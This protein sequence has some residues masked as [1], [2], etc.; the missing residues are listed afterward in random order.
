MVGWPY[1]HVIHKA[2]PISAP[3]VICRKGQVAIKSSRIIQISYYTTHTIATDLSLILWFLF[4][5]PSN[6]KLAFFG[7]FHSHNRP[8]I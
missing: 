5:G 8:L 6:K 7:F 1:K 3:D 2:R 4:E